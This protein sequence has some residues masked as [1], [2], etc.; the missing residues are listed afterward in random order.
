MDQRLLE[1][2]LDL[3][4]IRPGWLVLAADC[5]LQPLGDE[6]LAHPGDGARAN[7]KGSNDGVVA[8][9]WPVGD[10]GQQEDAGV[11][12]LAGRR[13][14]RRYHSR[15]SR[16]FV[17]RQVHPIF[18]HRSTPPTAA[19]AFPSLPALRIALRLSNEAG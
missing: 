19:R 13:L 1:V 2:A 5:G 10:I 4:L 15:Q 9:A 12:Q 3:D 6:L 7:A 14:P 16:P 8:V 17:L 18:L 11:G